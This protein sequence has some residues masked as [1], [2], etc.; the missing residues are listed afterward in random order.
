MCSVTLSMLTLIALVIFHKG[1]SQLLDENCIDQGGSASWMARI[2]S[3]MGFVCSGTLVHKRFVLTAAHCVKGQK[4]LYVN[5]GMASYYVHTVSIHRN[6]NDTTND[7]AML[8]LN[9]E[10]IFKT[11]NR[12]ICVVL[13]DEVISAA[14]PIFSAYGWN[15]SVSGSGSQPILQSLYVTQKNENE[16]QHG[17]T[18]ILITGRSVDSGSPLTATLNYRG[19][20]IIAQ[21]GIMSYGHDPSV[22][23]DVTSFKTW[24]SSRIKASEQN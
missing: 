2:Y 12:P 23:T 3:T 24:I 13:D 4:T 8:K 1:L 7:I 5:L 18:Q 9:N 14:I 10:V 17:R 22:Y 20:I 16:S 19:K 6:F 21:F 11:N 15:E